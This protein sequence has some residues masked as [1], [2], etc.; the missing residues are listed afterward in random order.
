[1]ICRARHR[2]QHIDR[3][4]CN[5]R[6][7]H[8]RAETAVADP[9]ELSGVVAPMAAQ[10]MSRHRPN[11][12]RVRRAYPHEFSVCGGGGQ[13]RHTR[14]GS[15]QEC[16]LTT[17]TDERPQPRPRYFGIALSSPASSRCELSHLRLFIVVVRDTAGPLSPCL[18][19]SAA[20]DITMRG[21][22]RRARWIAD[23]RYVRP[24]SGCT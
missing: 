7:Q 13:N 22:N 15:A 24:V 14:G 3:T 19:L 8:Q 21:N 23:W 4:R 10:T 11:C 18:C 6:N 2:D 5:I 12:P 9:S 1:M 17:S 20:D 16:R